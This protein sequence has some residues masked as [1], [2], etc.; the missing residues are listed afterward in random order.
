MSMQNTRGFAAMHGGKNDDNMKP[1]E[2]KDLA[3]GVIFNAQRTEAPLTFEDGCETGGTWPLHKVVSHCSAKTPA[4]AATQAAVLECKAF[5]SELSTI[6]CHTCRGFG[7]NDRKCA[8]KKK[9]TA[10]GKQSKL[11]Q[12]FLA[13]AAR[14]VF[15]SHGP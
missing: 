8:T 7:H 1:E 12:H 6:R 2:F 5:L 4:T 14:R 3:P 15:V 10:R 11:Q 13:A 9:I